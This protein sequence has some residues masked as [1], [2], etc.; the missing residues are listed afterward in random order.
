MTAPGR[1]RTDRAV[2]VGFDGSDGARAAVRWAA[3]EAGARGRPLVV[4]ESF[5]WGVPEAA[6][7]ATSASWR[8]G[9]D[10]LKLF[11]NEQLDG[12]VAE[13]RRE[14]P[15]LDVHG[16]LPEGRP[17]ETV[18]R[19][20]DDVDAE[21]LVL[22]ASG[23]GAVSRLVLGSTA[24]ELVRTVRQP[25]VVVRGDGAR[26]DRRTDR[27][28][29]VG[30]DGSTTSARAVGFA[31]AFAAR[32]HLPLHAVH[33]WS[34]RP[35]DLLEP[36]RIEQ[37]GP[38]ELRAETDEL[39]RRHVFAHQPDHPD[40]RVDW[41]SVTDRPAHALLDRAE[42]AALLVVG[43]HGRGPL[44]RALLGSVSHAVLYSAPCPV[45]VLRE[46]ETEPT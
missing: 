23:H 45:A 26:T 42:G 20:L 32:H 44:R 27:P 36:A 16:E 40:V 6:Q 17:E 29:V 15:D 7:G 21:L 10:R 34:D 22:G 25:V 28:V 38:E 18:P 41:T 19:V 9:E 43:S 24:D 37:P 2:V 33:A 5:E 11:A 31:F 46:P 39:A 8:L 3:H 14:W 13:I 12:V 1:D 4:V 35:L 30:V